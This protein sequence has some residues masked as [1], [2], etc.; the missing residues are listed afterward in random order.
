MLAPSRIAPLLS[1]KKWRP[2]SASNPWRPWKGTEWP[3]ECVYAMNIDGGGSCSP[4]GSVTALATYYIISESSSGTVVLVFCP[5]C[6]GLASRMFPRGWVVIGRH[7]IGWIRWV[8]SDWSCT[9][10][11]EIN[12][13]NRKAWG[14]E[15]RKI[16]ERRRGQQHLVLYKTGCALR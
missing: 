11:R 5:W 16:N 2:Q 12:R 7:D 13:R 10:L 9:I 3:S 15:Y 6:S 4:I 14:S 1:F 8:K